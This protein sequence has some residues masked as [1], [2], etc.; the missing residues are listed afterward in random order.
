MTKGLLILTL[1]KSAAVCAA[2]LLIFFAGCKKNEFGGNATVRGTVKHHARAVPG[3]RVFVKKGAKEFP[4]SDTTLYDITLIA[5][6][7]AA[8]SFKCYQG[9]YFIFAKG[10]DAGLPG[11]VQGGTHVKVRNKEHVDLDVAV[12]ED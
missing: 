8:F 5:D 4:G 12:T 7:D 10:F 6:R 11:N 1:N 2:V 9:D 3:S